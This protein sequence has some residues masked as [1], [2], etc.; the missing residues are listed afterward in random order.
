MLSKEA[1][2]RGEFVVVISGK[3]KKSVKSLDEIVHQQIKVLLKKFSLTEVVQIVH[4]LTHISKKEIYSAA[5][6]LKDE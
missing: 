3:Q 5:L 2:L 4:K 6:L 1:N